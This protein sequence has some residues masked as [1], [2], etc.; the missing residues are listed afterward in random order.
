MRTMRVACL[1]LLG[2]LT[3]WT[4]AA[5]A[6]EKKPLVLNMPA[7]IPELIEA[8]RFDPSL[9]EF[10]RN[11]EVI[12]TGMQCLLLGDRVPIS[13]QEGVG[14]WARPYYRGRPRV[15]FIDCVQRTGY[16]DM[17]ALARR[18]DMD[19]RFVQMPHV[20][21]VRG[22]K[23][24]P[25]FVTG[26]VYRKARETLARPYDVYVL[27]YG[28]QF[29]PKD[30]FDTI[31]KR[32]RAGAGM[33]VTNNW[34]TSWWAEQTP[35]KALLPA[36]GDGYRFRIAQHRVRQTGTTLWNGV[37]WE[38]MPP[39]TTGRSFK[40]KKGHKP[41][42]VN[43]DH[44][45]LYLESL[46]KGRMAVTGYNGLLPHVA[47]NLDHWAGCRDYVEYLASATAKVVLW[48]AGKASEVAIGAQIPKDVPAGQASSAAVTLRNTGRRA[49]T[50][51]LEGRL[52][53][54]S[55]ATL[56]QV[57][58]GQPIALAPG[59]TQT[60]RVPIAPAPA[61][62][63]VLD[64]VVRNGQGQSVQW[65]SF[66]VNVT[67]PCRCELS[68]DRESYG[69]GDTVRIAGKITGLAGAGWSADLTVTDVFD[70]V[71]HRE[72]PR[73]QPTGLSAA[74]AIK[75]ARG[76][77]FRIDLVLSQG[78]A[79]RVCATREFYVPKIGWDDYHSYIWYTNGA[80]HN[81]EHHYRTL[82]DYGGFETALSM[83]YTGH[84]IQSRTAALLGMPVVYTNVAPLS[85]DKV[86]ADPKRALT[87]NDAQ[88]IDAATRIRKYGAVAAFLQ[89]ERHSFKDPT[90]HPDL[91][92]AFQQDLKARYGAI[93][94]LNA[95]WGSTFKSWDA[96]R[97]TWS[98]DI[99]PDQLNLASWLEYRLFFSR[100]TIAQD[101]HAAD[102]VRKE[103]G[104]PL[105]VGIEG[106]FALAGHII[107]YSGF[108]YAGHM[109]HAFNCLMA[110]DGEQN[111]ATNLAKSFAPG[112][113]S[114]WL[115]YG[116]PKW[117][118]DGTPWWGVLHGWWGQ[119]WF[120]SGTMMNSLG[121]LT[122]QA[123]WAEKVTRPLRHGL[124]KL[125]MTSKRDTGPIVFLYDLPSLYTT[126]IAGKWI[127]PDNIHLM[128]RPSGWGRENLQRLC[129]EFGLQYSY[130]SAKQVEH[131]AL[132]GKKLLVLPD[133]MCMSEPTAA[134][135]KKFVAQGGTVLADLCPALWD[136][137][138][139]YLGGKGRLDDLFGVTR[140]KFAYK[141]LPTDY[142]VGGFGSD[143][144]FNVNNLWF[145]G[146]Y[147][148]RYLKVTDGKAMGKHLFENQ[149][150]FVLKRTGKGAALLMNFLETHY[151]RFPEHWQRGYFREV[152]R[153]AKVSSPVRVMAPKGGALW[154]YDVAR[155][156]DGAAEYVGVYRHS[157]SP[158]LNPN[159][160]RITLA[161]T[162]HVYDV[163]RQRYLGRAKA[164]Q[165]AIP[166]ADAALLA[167]LPYK[168]ARVTL[169]AGPGG[170]P[171][172]SVPVA[173]RVVAGNGRNPLGRHVLR[174][175]V[176]APSGRLSRAY[177][178]NV[179]AQKGQ[180]KGAIPTA[181]NEQP[182]RWRITVRDV[183]TGVSA[184]THYQIR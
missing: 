140:D 175:D 50:L 24:L 59:A 154:G 12:D 18:L 108:D 16:E 130:V 131:G 102:L 105:Y 53:D 44:A 178:A 180:Y 19:L 26:F 52:R 141:L 144:Q 123:T 45:W 83:G 14:H 181:L 4:A 182:G 166:A 149:P 117:Q 85:P 111:R 40:P 69:V 122:R 100:Q 126:F 32:V 11:A 5:H 94:K 28:T 63:I 96:V 147:Y 51:V 143:P 86:S 107:P 17:A 136:T 61:G 165:V 1:A 23:V 174:V 62:K 112:P 158:A 183:V 110:Y 15:V 46:G 157:N 91:L 170:K 138:G 142:L 38:V 132:A 118:Y 113:A 20:A 95:A 137:T 43:G 34:W 169:T 88:I 75:D 104:R 124:G 127:D 120:C 68:T 36:Q 153:L 133:V 81:A 135:I 31:L 42:A 156:M 29:L 93:G 58:P 163:R 37:P 164:A 79:A 66:V 159:T 84:D 87:A 179:V 82:R 121:G 160:V 67:S 27:G 146:E 9:G 77:V 168:V 103:V 134:A 92:K 35:L 60:V 129:E 3:V 167:V 73:V 76:T 161:R 65:G 6:A 139:R 47:I 72:S 25:D 54:W 145:I 172:V 7:T 125:L 119:A 41:V 99:K 152:L 39:C 155:F 101:K 56:G 30:C 150:A 64:L 98:K 8:C 74:Y 78:G 171:G 173:A 48:A 106:V 80:T 176:Y 128:N 148:E 184:E 10:A 114:S 2:A 13:R 22:K 162:G 21:W 177:S 115:G 151:Q 49:M 33:V 70:R 71:V 116:M 57:A 109:E 97:P 90:P 89:D 55:D